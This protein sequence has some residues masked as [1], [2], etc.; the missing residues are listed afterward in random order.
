MELAAWAG[1]ALPAIA[2]LPIDVTAAIALC[3][4]GAALALVA[5]MKGRWVLWAV[6]FI[7]STTT[8]ALIIG[9][10]PLWFC[11]GAAVALAA[12]AYVLSKSAIP[13]TPVPTGTY[14]VGIRKIDFYLGEYRQQI[15]LWYPANPAAGA[16][17]RRYFSPAEARA[18]GSVYRSMGLPGVFTGP[19]RMAQTHSYDDAPLAPPSAGTYPFVVFNHGGAMAPLQSFSLMEAL[20]SHGY[21]VLS[22][23][24]PGESAG[25]AWDDGSTTPI[26]KEGVRTLKNMDAAKASARFILSKTRDEQRQSFETLKS[27]FEETLCATTHAWSD[28]TSAVLDAISRDDIG[29]DAQEIMRHVNVSQV[30]FI[31]MSLGGSVSHDLCHRDKRAFAGVNLDGINWSFEW[32]GKPMSVPF[33]QIHADPDIMAAQA[34]RLLKTAKPPSGQQEQPLLPNDI[35]YETDGAAGRVKRYFWRQRGHMFFTDQPLT[36]KDASAHQDMRD[37]ADLVLAFLNPIFGKEPPRTMAAIAKSNPR[38]TEPTRF[39]ASPSA[40]H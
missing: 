35:Y 38:L 37:L 33:L 29:A 12:I 32:A 40:S 15:Y 7:A 19:Y 2:L 13:H 14:K 23:T 10:L 24:H 30:G 27:V 5:A 21:V 9:A 22:M 31:G 3:A 8:L 4:S 17:P 20:A 25:I 6:V 26:E 36:G 11:V 18:F 28:R 16:G 39:S 34:A 1:I